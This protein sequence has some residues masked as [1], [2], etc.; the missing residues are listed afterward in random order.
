MNDWPT[1]MQSNWY[2]LGNLLLWLA[3]LIDGWP[4]RQQ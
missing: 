1:W 2:E 4:G 3:F